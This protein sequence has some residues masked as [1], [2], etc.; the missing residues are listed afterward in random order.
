M[1]FKRLARYALAFLFLLSIV[2][3]IWLGLLFTEVKAQEGNQAH[4]SSPNTVDFPSVQAFLDVWDQEGN[5]VYGLKTE[6]ID[7]LEN[8]NSV[9]A[10]ELDHRQPGAQ[11]VFVIN[12]G[13]AFAIRD[14]N[15]LSRY[16]HVVQ[17]L[18][19]WADSR[20]G[21]TTDDLSLLGTEGVEITHLDSAERWLSSLLAF[22]PD[23]RNALPDYDVLSRGL[24]IA[25]DQTPRLGMGRSVI[26]I[27]SL[28]PDAVSFGFQNIVSRAN[29]ASVQINVWLVSSPERFTSQGAAQMR[30]LAT[31]T[32]GEFFGFSGLE[33]LPEIETFL[34]P[35]RNV[36]ILKY[37]SM[38]SNSGTH[39]LFVHVRAEDFEAISNQQS[40]E[41]E[42]LPPNVAFV[43]PKLE[44]SRTFLFDDGEDPDELIPKTQSLEVLVEFPDGYER[45]VE[46][47]TL[48][49]D[50][51][52]E[53]KNTTPPF[54]F[55]SWDLSDYT[56]SGNHTLRAE[57]VDELGLSSSTL[58][59]T[60]R[61]L[62]ETPK[63]NF[64]GQISRNRL[65]IVMVSAA[66]V[67][68]ILL[69][70]LVL[71]GRIHPGTLG[72]LRSRRNRTK[73]A[74]QYIQGSVKPISQK[75]PYWVNRLQWP[76]RHEAPNAIAH[77]T[78]LKESEDT[79]GSPNL[80]ILGED[81]LV[82]SDA[83]LATIRIDDPSVDPLHARFTY[84]GEGIFLLVDEDSL[85]GTWINY[86][87]VPQEGQYLEHGDLIHFGRVGFR[88][89]Y[90][91]P[92]RIPRLVILE[93]NWR[94]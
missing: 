69:L 17:H 56:N 7:I 79:E 49:V 38:I 12:P 51:Q 29:Q 36:Y 61:V 85:A 13:P 33:S 1:N 39:Q 53:S 67:G 8:E 76:Q 27:T 68:A 88:I 30:D 34:E 22:Q 90:H 11:V 86:T 20:A 59:L 77:L 19:A 94:R 14:S 4:L 31:Q 66:L 10:S 92:K 57:V 72:V 40:F 83:N 32:G 9:Q 6:D 63:V 78:P 46:Q 3:A 45:S 37:E 16:D 89:T 35:L 62:V 70:F 26:F 54:G 65:I 64:I 60:V 48:Y 93:E 84:N 43:S 2:L 44:I 73:P 58:E 24:E 15:G 25:A 82:G 50:G 42:V 18:Q 74:E 87:P 52:I 71:G 80:T 23:A 75:L 5:F 21:S 28:P 55:F 47:T 91:E 81:V 41:L